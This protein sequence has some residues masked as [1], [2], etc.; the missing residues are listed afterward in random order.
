MK[1]LG[2]S[3]Y[4]KTVTNKERHRDVKYCT[5]DNVSALVNDPRFRV[6]NPLTEDTY[7]VELSKKTIKLD[8]PLH[9][10]F[11]VYQYAKLKMLTF[12]YDFLDEFIDRQDFQLCEMDTDSFY[13]ALSTHSLEAAVKPEKQREFYETW[14]QWFPAEACDQ[15]H[16]EFVIAKCRGQTWKPTD[17][18]CIERKSYD[19]RTPG[20]FKVEW[21]GDGIIGLCSKTYYCFGSNTDKYSCKGISKRQNQLDKQ[22]YLNVLQTKESGHGTNRGF[23]VKDNKM[24]T[25]EQDR[26]GLVFFYPKR[27]VAPDS[28]STA[29]TL[30]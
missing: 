13:M 26:A 8:L 2:N 30:L 11:F 20:L 1:L 25:Y 28:I 5:E 17:S 23:R 22:R 18:C 27:I 9:I 6:L 10:G 24:Y 3:G 7:E 12:Y 15:H 16:P 29:P 14:P 4:G 21:E 19:K